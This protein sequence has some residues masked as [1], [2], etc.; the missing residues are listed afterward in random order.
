MEKIGSGRLHPLWRGQERGFLAGSD[1]HHERIG[2]A[3]LL[4]VLMIERRCRIRTEESGQY[5]LRLPAVIT[6]QSK[7][8]RQDARNAT[9]GACELDPAAKLRFKFGLIRR[10]AAGAMCGNVEDFS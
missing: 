9:R 5:A 2:G 6:G 10:R 1:F 7:S 4:L 8:R 3:R